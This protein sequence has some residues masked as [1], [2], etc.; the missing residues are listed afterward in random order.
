MKIYMCDVNLGECILI[1]DKRRLMVVDCGA[2]FGQDEHHAELAARQAMQ[3]GLNELQK[4]SPMREKTLVITHM[5]SVHY[6][7]LSGLPREL[8]FKRIYLPRYFYKKTAKGYETGGLFYRMAWARAF[9]YLTGHPGKLT[10]LQQLL[11][12]LPER[13]EEG[14]EVRCVSQDDIIQGAGT[15]YRV[16]W[17]HRQAELMRNEPLVDRLR[18]L[19]DEVLHRRGRMNEKEHTL[20]VLEEYALRLLELYDF[21]ASAPYREGGRGNAERQQKRI[22]ER[23]KREQHLIEAFEALRALPRLEL[24]R[25]EAGRSGYVTRE[26]LEELNACSLVFEQPEQLLACGDATPEV[27]RYLD[28]MNLIATRYRVLKLPFHGVESYVSPCLPQAEVGLISNS[29]DH[30]RDWV[31]SRRCAELAVE[32]LCC[33]NADG[34]RCELYNE[35]MPPQCAAC[36]IWRGGRDRCVELKPGKPVK[37]I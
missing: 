31:I 32:Q 34:K 5:D 25:S 7:A 14:G 6:N 37:I 20:A 17:P 29:G 11:L 24:T 10:H 23:Q 21:Y 8:R 1:S 12:R 4:R 13:L 33:T 16:L 19:L 9:F 18:E 30:Q 3:R 22:E 35:G 26:L 15:K 27:L 36:Q 2:R 28:A